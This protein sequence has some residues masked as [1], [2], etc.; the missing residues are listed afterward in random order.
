[1]LSDVRTQKT[2]SGRV[3]GNT[4]P[5]VPARRR[6]ASLAVEHTADPCVSQVEIIRNETCPCRNPSLLDAPSL[7]FTSSRYLVCHAR[8]SSAV[9]RGQKLAHREGEGAMR[10]KP[11]RWESNPIKTFPHAAS[12]R[13]GVSRSAHK[14]RAD[15][16]AIRKTSPTDEPHSQ[17]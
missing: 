8:E 11:Q 4:S 9:R 12:P 5:V 7:I 17:H 2:D 13:V 14:K 6:L 3:V 10:P 1:M 16:R 15:T